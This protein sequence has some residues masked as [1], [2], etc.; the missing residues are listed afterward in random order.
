MLSLPELIE[1]YQTLSAEQLD[2]LVEL[3]NLVAQ[4]APGAA[5]EIRRQGL[6]YYWAERGGPVGAGICQ[7]LP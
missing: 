5:E 7:I 6:V 4:I 3:R 2:I 1:H